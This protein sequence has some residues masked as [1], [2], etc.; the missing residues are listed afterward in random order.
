M[1]KGKHSRKS[2]SD[3]VD[4]V[5]AVPESEPAVPLEAGV[6]PSPDSVGVET[7]AKALELE[8]RLLRLQADFDNFRKR[9]ARERGETYARANED[10]MMELIPVLD[11]MD[12]ALASAAAHGA[13]QSL[14]DGVCLVAEQL[15]GTLGKFG[16]EKIDASGARFDP[17]EQEA[18]AHL[19][20]ET[21]L[22][23]MVIE[24][25]RMGY[26]LKGRVL[27][28]AQVVVSSGKGSESQPAEQP[29][30]KG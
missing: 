17:N 23:N 24:Q 25:T 22:D 27:R 29:E 10:L 19:P 20:S 8:N 11:H 14:L 3:N 18:I 28:P 15:K 6:T 7:D 21:V 4:E 12:M 9:V 1:V 5:P 16:L 2:Q 26:K 30:V 13:P